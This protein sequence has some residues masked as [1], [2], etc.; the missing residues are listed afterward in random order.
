MRG[1][2]PGF[3]TMIKADAAEDV[4]MHMNDLGRLSSIH[5]FNSFRSVCLIMSTCG[6]KGVFFHQLGVLHGQ[7]NAGVVVRHRLL[8]LKRPTSNHGILGVLVWLQE[9][10]HLWP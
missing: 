5:C 2:E 7:H 9:W 6:Q 4:D 1:A 10:I 3:L 8:F